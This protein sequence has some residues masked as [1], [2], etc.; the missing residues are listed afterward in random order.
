[1]LP[2]SLKRMSWSLP[3]FEKNSRSIIV[4]QEQQAITIDSTKYSAPLKVR[5]REIK[6]KLVTTSTIKAVKAHGHAI[7]LQLIEGNAMGPEAIRFLRGQLDQTAEELYPAFGVSRKT[8]YRWS[9]GTDPMPRSAWLVLARI[10]QERE[11]GG[12]AMLGLLL[13]SGRTK[14]A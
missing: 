2:S 14:A 11:E 6:G 4:S 10:I 5:L 8:F 1:M 12:D 9:K 3:S 7:A 13:S